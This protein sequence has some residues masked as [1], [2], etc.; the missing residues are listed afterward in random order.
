M[1]LFR[2]NPGKYRNIITIQRIIGE[3]RNNLGE[4]DEENPFNWENVITLRAGI[5]PI[6]GKEVLT[7][8]YANADMTHRVQFR[9]IPIPIDSTMRILFGNRIFRITAPPINY[10]ERNVEYQL[11]CREEEVI[12]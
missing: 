5:F 12:R 6:S 10:Q 1:S 11:Y 2:I 8:E 4:I 9:W 3:N 7:I